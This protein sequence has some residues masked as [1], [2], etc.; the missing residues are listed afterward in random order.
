MDKKTV[1]IPFYWISKGVLELVWKLEYFKIRFFIVLLF[2]FRHNPWVVANC[3]EAD[4]W[5]FLALRN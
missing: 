5:P 3:P 4:F 2:L 1:F